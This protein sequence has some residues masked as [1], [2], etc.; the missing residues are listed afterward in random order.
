MSTSLSERPPHSPTHGS[1][2]TSTASDF[3]LSRIFA[4]LWRGRWVILFFAVVSAGFGVHYVQKRGTIWRATSRLYVDNQ[5]LNVSGSEI[6][7]GMAS[8]NH[9]NT[10]AELIRSG[11][12]LQ[13]A[14]SGTELGSLEIFRGVKNRIAWLKKKLRV[15]VG[16]NSDIITVSLEHKLV[17]DACVVVRR[18]VEEYRDYHMMQ[19]DTTLDVV[20]NRLISAQKDVEGRLASKIKERARFLESNG[21]VGKE[22]M[23]FVDAK[24]AATLAELQRVREELR[25]LDRRLSAIRPFVK[26]PGLVLRLLSSKG[27][28][29]VVRDSLIAEAREDVRTIQQ[30]LRAMTVEVT[31]SHPRVRALQAQIKEL[32]NRIAERESALAKMHI[33]SLEEARRA[34]AQEEQALAK[35][36]DQQEALVQSITKKA[37]EL[38]SLKLEIADARASARTVRERLAAVNMNK[39]DAKDIRVNILDYADPSTATIAVG[40]TKTIALLGILGVLFGSLLVWLREMLNH[41]IRTLEDMTSRVGL[42]VV[43]VVPRTNLPKGI[44]ALA[45]WRASRALSEAARSLRTAVYFA[46][47]EDDQRVLHIT[48]PDPAEGK[49]LIAAC[50]GIAM[51]QAGQKTLIIDADMRK[52]RQDQLFEEG[53][54]RGLADLLAGN[55]GGDAIVATEQAGL[56]LL[57][58]GPSPE[59]P[60]ELLSSLAFEALLAKFR[61]KYDRIIVDSPPILPVADA[62]IL[63]KK[64]DFSLVVTRIDKSTIKRAT[65]ARSD[66]AKLGANIL[67]CVVNDMPNKLGY[68]YNSGYGYGST[69]GAQVAPHESA[70]KSKQG[71]LSGR[72]SSPSKRRSTASR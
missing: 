53:N 43:G 12:I 33:A 62:R 24:H 39:V 68:G 28:A 21:T 4:L 51:A 9:A 2:P 60:A 63:G 32:E 69:G 19:S 47:S 65:Q 50:L 18:V 34:V 72:R 27:S 8:M 49:S 29:A 54:S 36:A 14:L 7:L 31:E 22:S 37:V 25:G 55:K 3:Q 70:H 16:K 38:D 41:R 59:N 56:D 6:F 11:P 45:A 71:G 64:C 10:Q 67:G 23:A 35:Q 42:P 15:G 26:D 48:S 44:P 52:P 30:Q 1:M 20:V 46:M 66:L 17:G 5:S 58:S 40:K 13:K 61:S 57:P